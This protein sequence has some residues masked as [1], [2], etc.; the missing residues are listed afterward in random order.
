M[1]KMLLLSCAALVL[2]SSQAKAEELKIG[3]VNVKS[4][5]EKSKHG[6]DEKVAFEALKKQMTETL[7]KSDKELADLAKKLE[8]QDYLDSLSP[9]AEN[10]LKGRFEGLSQ[11]FA[12]Y[13]NQYY[14]LL[15]QANYRML[16]SLHEAISKAS[17]EVRAKQK[18][19]FILNQ[20]S[21][22]AAASAYDLTEEVIKSMNSAYEKQKGNT[23]S[24]DQKTPKA[25]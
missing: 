5:I 3:Y 22:F 20:D 19:S 14:Q 12:R 24:L 9:A 10:E 16:S 8:D 1:K 4:C 2:F 25:A 15:Q 23:A 11:E 6:N 13:Q 21:A 18:F 17:E 7:E